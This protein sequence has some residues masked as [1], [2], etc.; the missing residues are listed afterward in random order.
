M[1]CPPTPH[2]ASIVHGVTVLTLSQDVR[3]QGPFAP[4]SAWVLQV[5]GTPGLS[6][7]KYWRPIPMPWDVAAL[8]K[9]ETA[10]LI[11]SHF[12]WPAAVMSSIDD[13]LSNRM[14]MS[15]GT[16]SIFRIP[17]VHDAPSGVGPAS[18]TA[19]S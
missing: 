7:G 9:D 2:S 16:G 3:K 15:S 14:Y 12:R 13:D 1:Q 18:P 6:S 19:A 8:T 4:H 5:R 17:W 10:E 11:A